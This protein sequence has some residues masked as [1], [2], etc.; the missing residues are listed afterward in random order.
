MER[1]KNMCPV[2]KRY[3]NQD[4]YRKSVEMDKEE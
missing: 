2:C 3:E 4:K 1:E